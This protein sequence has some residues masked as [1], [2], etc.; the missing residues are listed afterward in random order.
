MML[1]I[2]Y[3]NVITKFSVT[4]ANVYGCFAITTNFGAI[5][6]TQGLVIGTLGPVLR[7]R[8]NNGQQGAAVYEPP[9]L[10]VG[11]P[12]VKKCTILP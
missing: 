7:R 1:N 12:D 10:V 2:S 11:V 4:N 6:S 9:Y 5:C 3:N 8:R